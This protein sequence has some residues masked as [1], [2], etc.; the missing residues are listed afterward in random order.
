MFLFIISGVGNWMN[1]YDVKK[2]HEISVSS[3]NVSMECSLFL[4]K[5][6]ERASFLKSVEFFHT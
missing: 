1:M 3:S 6:N 4:A 5:G 2:M